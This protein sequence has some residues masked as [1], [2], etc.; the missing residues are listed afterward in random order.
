[1]YQQSRINTAFVGFISNAGAKDV[2]CETMQYEL[3]S[4][5]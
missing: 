3:F 5:R 2:Q 4:Y 1:M